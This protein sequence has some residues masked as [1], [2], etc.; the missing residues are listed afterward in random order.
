[1]TSS[2][3][4]IAGHKTCQP[5][6]Q[7][8]RL[9]VQGS[10]PR[11]PSDYDDEGTPESW[12]TPG[13][14]VQGL[15]IGRGVGARSMASR[16]TDSTSPPHESSRLLNPASA[17]RTESSTRDRPNDLAHPATPCVLPQRRRSSGIVAN[18]GAVVRRVRSSTSVS[19]PPNLEL[20]RIHGAIR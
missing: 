16:L 19:R 14:S 2:R 18:R 1:L 4:G 9:Q 7:Q 13:P 15:S 3:P 10:V 20:E 11:E 17:L 8:T 12:R 5:D 6:R